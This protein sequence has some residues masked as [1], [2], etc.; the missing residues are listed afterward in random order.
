[1]PGNAPTPDPRVIEAYLDDVAAELDAATRL[2]TAPP[3]RFAAFHLQQAA[4]KLVKAVRLHRG[5]VATNDHNLVALVAE[6]PENDSWRARLDA[7]GTLSAYATAYRYPSPG[8]RRRTGPESA[9]VAT[10]IKTITERL[11]EARRDLLPVS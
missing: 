10:W 1:M 8:G 9:E 5:L 6:L 7:L 4:E 2:S 11:S 3:S